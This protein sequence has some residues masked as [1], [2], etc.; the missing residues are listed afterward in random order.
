[1]EAPILAAMITAG[2][3]LASTMFQKWSRKPAAEETAVQNFVGAHYDTLRALLSDHCVLILKKME[4]GQNHDLAELRSWL[5][6]DLA[7]P[8]YEEQVLF[9]KEFEYRLR[10]MEA[11]G[12]ITKPTSEYYITD[13]GMSFVQQARRNRDFFRVLF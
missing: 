9:E 12:V 7:L 11:V 8:S 2:A 10:F 6:P 4:D 13:V 1:M 5:Y 3:N